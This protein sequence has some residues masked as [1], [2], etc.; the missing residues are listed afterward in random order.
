MN[1]T[2]LKD[3]F[4]ITSNF[5]QS[6]TKD[7][8]GDENLRNKINENQEKIKRNFFDKMK[9]KEL[10]LEKNIAIS[11]NFIL[12]FISI[13]TF[14]ILIGLCEN[15]FSNLIAIFYPFISS[16]KSL[17]TDTLDDDKMWLTYWVVFS[18]Y[19]IVENIFGFILKKIP[20]YFFFKAGIFVYLHLP[21]TRGAELVY[22]KLIKTTFIK[23]ERNVDQLISEL[24]Q[25][26]KVISKNAKDLFNKQ[27]IEITKKFNNSNNDLVINKDTCKDE[28]EVENYNKDPIQ[29]KNQ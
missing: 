15:F 5:E 8:K 20:N 25:D 11:T 23:C 3:D 28:K 16:L 9:F 2:I 22:R 10:E 21:Y 7:S 1:T 14:F 4:K 24:Q 18:F 29:K 26:T 19:F 17:E 6:P 12:I 27:A 13:F